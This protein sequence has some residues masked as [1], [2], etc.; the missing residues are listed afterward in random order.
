MDKLKV[1]VASGNKNKLREFEQI[2]SLICPVEVV[3][4]KSLIPDFDPEETGTTF[5]ANARIKV[6]ALYEGASKDVRILYGGS[7]KP[8]NIATYLSQNNVDGALVGG[9]S[10]TVESFSEMINALIA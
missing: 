9:A 6:E 4:A 7:V 10:L 5:L 8:N 2:L 3:P 1:I